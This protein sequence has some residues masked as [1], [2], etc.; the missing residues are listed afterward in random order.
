MRLLNTLLLMTVITLAVVIGAANRAPVWISFDPLSDDKPAIAADVPLFMIVWVAAFIGLILGFWAMWLAQA[1]HRRS[2][3]ELR[4]I[5]KEM[6]HQAG[7][8]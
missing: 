4:E 1:R 8:R 6:V 2:T 5:R 7:R 3:R